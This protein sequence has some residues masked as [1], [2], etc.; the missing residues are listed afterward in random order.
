MR[1]PPQIKAIRMRGRFPELDAELC[2]GCGL[3]EE[4]CIVRDRKAIRVF[5]NRTDPEKAA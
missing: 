2:T 1:C 5:N 3:C 4:V